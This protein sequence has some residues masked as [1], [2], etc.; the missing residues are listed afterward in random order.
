[1]NF[2]MYEAYELLDENTDNK[3]LKEATVNFAIQ[4]GFDK[5]YP[6]LHNNPNSICIHHLDGDKDN[7]NLSNLGLIP[8]NIHAKEHGYI[9]ST[10][11]KNYKSPELVKYNNWFLIKEKSLLTLNDLMLALAKELD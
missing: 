11:N 4:L 5:D 7:H 2:F 3:S 8:R 10:L 9:N 1:M 6:W